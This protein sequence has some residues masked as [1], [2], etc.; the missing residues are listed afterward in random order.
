MNSKTLQGQITYEQIVINKNLKYFK[1]SSLQNQ[2]TFA[3]ELQTSLNSTPK[4]ISP[5]FFYDENG[6][7]LFDE[8][9]SLPEYYPYDSE[10]EIL[11]NIESGIKPYVDSDIRLVELGSGSSIKTRL[12]LN[13]LYNIQKNVEYFPIDISD[14]LSHSVQELCNRYNDLKITGL[15]DTYE[16]GLNFIEHY[17]DKPNLIS[18]LGSS[19]GNFN[20]DEGMKFLKTIHDMMKHSDFLLIGF[21]LKKDAVI[22]HN[23]YND[24]KGITAKFNLNVLNRINRE[25][26]ADF[27]LTKFAHYAFYNESVSYTHLTLPTNREV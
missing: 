5:K 15:I 6:S 10:I 4:Y 2:K 18:F 16:N 13:A 14:I 25:L 23:A 12:L 19:F 26:E 17:D 22:L 21:D 24:S 20:H 3:A 1:S 7:N 11:K 27:D 9:C 8:I